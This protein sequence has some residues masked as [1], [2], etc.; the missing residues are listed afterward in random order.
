[1]TTQST[2]PSFA[3]DSSLDEGEL[4]ETL[5]SESATEWHHSNLTIESFEEELPN[6]LLKNVQFEGNIPQ[7]LFWIQSYISLCNHKSGHN[8]Q[9]PPSGKLYFLMT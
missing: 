5:S 6:I 9:N 1:M 4:N 8:N 3:E 7:T 2:V